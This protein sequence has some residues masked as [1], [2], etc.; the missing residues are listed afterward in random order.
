MLHPQAWQVLE[1]AIKCSKSF[2]IAAY[3]VLTLN[4]LVSVGLEEGGLM[5]FLF[6]TTL[7]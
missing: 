4:T 3:L 1:M 7:L 5:S 6:M 2:L